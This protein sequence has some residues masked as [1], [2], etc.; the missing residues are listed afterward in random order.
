LISIP[1]RLPNASYEIRVGRRLLAQLHEQL[2][3]ADLSEPIL[4]ISQPRILK[5]V[6]KRLKT[7]C[8]TAVMPDGE[9]AK[10]L[11]TVER[12]ID[13]MA[14]LKMSRQSTVVAL[15]GGLVGDVA[16]FAASIY[17]RG[18]AVV[19][20]P[21]TLLAQ[22]DSS[23]GGKTA[24]NH[25]VAKNL[26]GSFHQPKLVLT[27]PDL[28]ETLPARE[29]TNGLYEALKYG[30][31][32]DP[33]LFSEFETSTAALLSRD[34]QVIESL[35]AACAAIKADVVQSDE[36]E[37]G[38]RRILNFGHTIGHALE[39]AGGYRRLKHGEAVGYG[40]I[41]A[42]RIAEGLGLLPETDRLRIEGAVRA[43]GRLP[44][45]S[46]LRAPGVLAALQHDKKIRD[47][48]VHFVLPRAIGKVEITA[49]VPFTLV[50]DTVRGLLRENSRAS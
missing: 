38:V 8:A 41:A 29:Y 24:V 21:T 39:A 32:R 15:G 11:R 43:I 35:V 33:K 37:G 26:I 6:G 34:P 10:T 9:R 46:G 49:D 19:Q 44:T 28:L 48:A 4:V 1:I 50:G 7:R 18:V 42:S 20:V 30:V 14:R 22:L 12:L 27:D 2:A 25:R 16:G 45:L 3:A 23:I 36:R 17:M 40:M 31:I 5:A 13:E 47:G